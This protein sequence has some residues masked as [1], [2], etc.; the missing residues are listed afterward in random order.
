MSPT[1]RQFI[2]ALAAAGV[3]HRSRAM[4]LETITPEQF[5]AAG[6]GRSND[7]DAF[8]ALSAHVN[9]RGGGIVALRPVTYLVGKQFRGPGPGA[10]FAF[11]PRN[12]LHF[13]NCS[14]GVI[15]EGN[16]AT[17]R[18]APGLRYGA[19]DPG[20]GAALPQSRAN[21]EV[22]RRASPYLGMIDVVNC[23]GAVEIA[24]IELDGNLDELVVGGKY[25]AQGWQAWGCGIRFTGNSGAA[26]LSRIHS[27][28]HPFDGII[29]TD[30]PLRSA[31]TM[32]SDCTCDFNAR[33]GCSI[34]S[35]RNYTFE[36]CRFSNTG[37]AGMLS[38][39]ASG[40]D[41]EAE[42]ST[43]RNVR[44]KDCDFVNNA[45]LGLVAASGDSAEITFDG[46]KFVGTTYWSA[47][48]DKPAME[49]SNCLFV[50]SII[51][52]HGDPRPTMA[53]QFLDCTFSDDP[54]LS[55]TGKVFCGEPPSAAI[56]VLPD[57]RNVRFSHCHFRLSGAAVL[58]SSGPGV[59]YDSCDMVQR[60][61]SPSAPRGTYVGTT[62]IRG[63]AH[64]EGSRVFG[65]VLLNGRRWAPAAG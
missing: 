10:P 47:W 52:A 21:L 4:A 46:C 33:T 14:R 45:R 7:T 13:E 17:L 53:T 43:V 41:I 35:G 48:P 23:S 37:R 49:F 65:E 55:P 8:T 36:R 27:H 63:N 42:A 51:H 1:R 9:S 24:D 3:A 59:I 29:F 16:G 2:G 57:N 34:T 40:F 64:L 6:D 60:S 32:I 11:N 12:I 19:F 5:G 26:R 25:G 54:A 44:F 58:P 20:S 18:C 38:S 62:T 30:D 28:H 15:I 31:S 22:S 61:S 50:G 56:A 39:P